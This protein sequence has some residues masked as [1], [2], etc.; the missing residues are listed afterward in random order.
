MPVDSPQV[1]GG[2]W[3]EAAGSAPLSPRQA[4]LSP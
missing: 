2:R 1:P 3:G 4:I